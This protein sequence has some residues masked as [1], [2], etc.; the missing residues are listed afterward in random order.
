MSGSRQRAAP[1]AANEPRKALRDQLPEGQPSPHPAKN[2]KPAAA[3][4][5]HPHPLR[6]PAR[7]AALSA[8]RRRGQRTLQGLQR[9]TPRRPAKP[10]PCEEPKASGRQAATPPTSLRTPSRA[11]A[12]SAPCRPRPTNPARPSATNS[13]KA[14]QAHTLQRTR[15]Q[16]PPSCNTPPFPSRRRTKRPH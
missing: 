9:P 5:Q 14:S 3:R 6:T 4:P 16:R 1:P 10:T 2:Q 11:A 8:P 7:A 15:S 12:G 13:P